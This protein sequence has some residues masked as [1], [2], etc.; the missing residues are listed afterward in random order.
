MLDPQL[1]EGGHHEAAAAQ[2]DPQ[3]I[4]ELGVLSNHW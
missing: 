1:R 3:V 4:E 2:F